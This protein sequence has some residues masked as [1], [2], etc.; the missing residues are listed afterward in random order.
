[1][2]RREVISAEKAHNGRAEKSLYE[3]DYYA[4]VQEQ[5]AALEQGDFGALDRIHLADEVGDLGRSVKKAIR[6]NL[7][8]LLIHLV[9]WA[10]QPERRKGGW[11]VS[12]DEHRTRLLQDLAESPSLRSYVSEVLAA[13]YRLARKRA[14]VQMRV[15]IRNIPEACPFSVNEVLDPD[16][17]SR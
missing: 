10:Y 13:E 8:V 9:K 7:N 11:E 14:A 4:W 12:I 3:A 2:G 6:S 15:A 17:L 5:A 16:F 1:M